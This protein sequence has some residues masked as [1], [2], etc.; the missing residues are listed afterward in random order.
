MQNCQTKYSEI[1]RGEIG[2]DSI[3]FPQNGAP[4]LDIESTTKSIEIDG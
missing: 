1:D 4:N 2:F 3:A